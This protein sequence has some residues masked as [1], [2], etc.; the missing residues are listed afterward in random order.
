[1]SNDL[2]LVVV[3]NTKQH[4][5][6]TYY[7]P[8]DQPTTQPTSSKLNLQIQYVNTTSMYP[9]SPNR[10]PTKDHL[11]G[12]SI[13]FN[14]SQGE[15]RAYS[16]FVDI[17]TLRVNTDSW[18]P[19]YL[20]NH[21]K[22][23]SGEWEDYKNDILKSREE[24]RSMYNLLKNQ[25][26]QKNDKNKKKEGEGVIPQSNFDMHKFTKMIKNIKI[27]E[28][29]V[30][31]P[32][33]LEK[34]GSKSGKR[35]KNKSIPRQEPHSSSKDRAIRMDLINKIC[36]KCDIEPQA[37][38]PTNLNVTHEISDGLSSLINGILEIISKIDIASISSGVTDSIKNLADSVKHIAEDGLQVKHS[39]ISSLWEFAKSN[40][41]LVAF[42]FLVC[43]GIYFR[44]SCDTSLIVS[45][46]KYLA[47]FV[48][49]RLIGTC[50][51]LNG[52]LR[53]IV[54]WCSFTADDV[55]PHM[56]GGCIIDSVIAYIFLGHLSKA[57]E[58]QHASEM[59]TSFFEKTASMKKVKEGAEFTFNFFINKLQA[60]L[61]YMS[62]NFGMKE[63]HIAMDKMPHITEFAAQV[64]D[65]VN[66]Y[67]RGK[68]LNFESAEEI[69]AVHRKG[70]KLQKEIP[71]GPEYMESR[72]LLITAIA[73]LSPLLK[74][75]QRTN[76]YNN[77]PRIEPVGVFFTGPPGVGK[78]TALIP[79]L[80]AVTASTLPADKRKAFETNHND[81]I[82][83]RIAEN[84]FYDSY[85]GQWN[86]IFDDLGQAKDVAG[87]QCNVF[88]EFIRM[89]NSNNM[90]LH[91]AHLE[92]KG[93]V[94]FR[95]KIVWATSNVQQ[96][97]LNS[98][99]RSDALTRR[100]KKSYMVIPA[101]G[102][103]V[104]EEEPDPWKME[105]I[106]DKHSDDYSHLIF[107]R[108]NAL[109]GELIDGEE[110]TISMVIEE[111]IEQFQKNEDTGEKLLQSQQSFKEK[112]LNRAYNNSAKDTF[113]KSSS[114][115][116][117]FIHLRE[118]FSQ[119]EK[120]E[121]DIDPQGNVKIT[122]THD[123]LLKMA[124]I[125]DISTEVMQEYFPNVT[126]RFSIAGTFD[127]ED[128]A[129]LMDEFA[130]KR[131]VQM[132]S[133]LKQQ[134]RSY[135]DWCVSI[136]NKVCGAIMD[137]GLYPILS[138]L[139]Q[140]MVGFFAARAIFSWILP[141]AEKMAKMTTDDGNPVY[142]M[143]PPLK[144]GCSYYSK[145][146][147]DSE[148]G[149]RWAKFDDK[150]HF[151][152]NS[153]PPLDDM[154]DCETVEWLQLSEMISQSALRNRGGGR[155]RT[156]GVK[157][158]SQKKTFKPRHTKNAGRGHRQRG[159]KVEIDPQLAYDSNCHDIMTKIFKKN[160]Y[161]IRI[162]GHETFMGFITFIAGHD[163]IMP[164]HFTETIYEL[165]ELGALKDTDSVELVPCSNRGNSFKIQIKD[166]EPFYPD[167]WE[168]DDIVIVRFPNTIPNAPD[169]R[170]YFLDDF[171]RTTGRFTGSLLTPDLN[172]NCRI[173]TTYMM[174][175]RDLPY[176]EYE[177][178]SAF[179]YNIPTA[180]GDCGA[181]CAIA[182]PTT[183][184]RKL[185]GL[186]VAGK[187]TGGTGYAV[188]V[189]KDM[190]DHFYEF[191]SEPS[192]KNDTSYDDK[193]A[194]MDVDPKIA[195]FLNLYKAPKSNVP[196]DTN[197]VPSP[198]HNT[199][200]QSTCIPGPLRSFTNDEGVVIDP[201]SLA[202]LNYARQTMAISID[203][204]QMCTSSYANR[205]VIASCN[206]VT[207]EPRIFSFE[208]AVRGIPGIP[209]C[210]GIPRNTSAGYP[211]NLD[212]PPGE[213]G[214]SHFFGKEGDYEFT[215][216]HCKKLR[217]R[218]EYIIEKA[219]EGIRIEHIY[220][221]F[222]KDERR[223][224]EKAQAGKARLVSASPVCLLICM[225]IYFM[226]FVRWYMNNRLVNGSA[227][228]INPYSTDWDTMYRMFNGSRK[229]KNMI[230]GDFKAYDGSISR[231]IMIQ[232]LEFINKWY[233]DD[234][235]LIR[236]VLFEEVCNSKHI[237]EDMVYEWTGGNPSGCFLTTILN[238]FCNNIIMRYGCLLAYATHL[239]RE[240]GTPSLDP[241]ETST[242][243][244]LFEKH[245][246]ML[247]FGDDNELSVGEG[248]MPWFNQ[249]TLH[250]ELPKFGFEYTL[251][252]KEISNTEPYRNIF[253]TT[254][255]KRSW[256]FEPIL[257]RIVAPLEISVILEMAQ[258]TKKKDRNFEYVRTNV[259][260]ALKE[261][262]V[263]DAKL[264][265]MWAEPIKRNAL[266]KLDHFTTVTDRRNAMALQIARSLVDLE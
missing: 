106:K 125:Y 180:V 31:N 146:Q 68:V 117:P 134:I 17:K 107:L 138:V 66:E 123:E 210:E 228:G 95:S 38:F 254:F 156:P 42:L 195:G 231:I 30:D 5:I 144:P 108:H 6:T 199:Y 34:R 28:Q 128:L 145:F 93:N 12:K 73:E 258:W 212:L 181:L 255:L 221:D 220:N 176:L 118:K 44:D 177:S 248:T 178:A 58:K 60:L 43:I 211:Y 97:K 218:V 90:D 4:H 127:V 164:L 203:H 245:V 158:K 193:E 51:V 142:C 41:P 196:K 230:A 261:L 247:A 22:V 74:K 83:N 189:S 94:N 257:S 55:E 20:D 25:K 153:S 21:G 46:V 85:N 182:D 186:H 70:M 87:A 110:L 135:K 126:D 132:D 238:T 3:S 159:G 23:A 14:I 216:E 151:V 155:N 88:M 167:E 251:E 246:F 243:L 236:E 36:A 78:T 56:Y 53:K 249:Q 222:L 86:C 80:L 40:A 197:I 150:G 104:N 260:N 226:D 233:N 35:T 98:L 67:A 192:I 240:A 54:S 61:N 219:K 224:I 99:I 89:V 172:G 170:K 229:V 13:K 253:S 201:W 171:D 239:G 215:S 241:L 24:G 18:H 235:N 120:V 39:F 242:A 204:L 59:L 198:L 208:E 49:S 119:R 232:F 234:N 33:N 252:N 202:R 77:G 109:T 185:I 113:R 237:Y 37:L 263:H 26:K 209:N 160:M 121:D 259:D 265:E 72:K 139:V 165:V 71:I 140:F 184:A 187:K 174:G 115:P 137:T 122:M 65:L 227:V 101:R 116:S 75:I 244:S 79:I 84:V 82:Y 213:R 11:R 141:N 76:L 10:S 114:C 217:E 266:F 9:T 161:S 194:Q 91:M 205:M 149:Y 256:R 183:G 188:K 173:N 62:K 175:I 190:I 207:W 162:A 129:K 148:K 225:R 154:K 166:L 223:P 81:F 191:F 7:K 130:R 69:L 50:S 111:L 103:R 96:F 64:E 105:K 1:M 48:L 200:S 136:Y 131:T 169:I 63:F 214:K 92:D 124:G 47:N 100:F 112:Y 157:D 45:I 250:K 143:Y 264:W 262:S 2:I 133:P 168:G 19:I 57:M 179:S 163:A 8:A 32:R 27:A 102:Y 206:D 16:A 52:L 15:S 152:D 29:C 147:D